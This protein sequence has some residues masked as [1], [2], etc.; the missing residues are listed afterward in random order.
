MKIGFAPNV[1]GLMIQHFLFFNFISLISQSILC[2]DFTFTF[3]KS[4][5]IF[6]SIENY[7]FNLLLNNKFQNVNMADRQ[8][9]KKI[10]F[11]FL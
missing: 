10:K 2:Q 8:T 3:T 5:F 4:V 9:R 11:F 1:Q 7:S 6:N